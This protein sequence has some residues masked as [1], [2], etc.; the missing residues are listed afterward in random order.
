[1]LELLRG[2]VNPGANGRQVLSGLIPG[3][4]GARGILFGPL[5]RFARSGQDAVGFRGGL[6]RGSG[7]P[8]RLRRLLAEGR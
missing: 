6:A 1:L 4:V 5:D 7:S 2:L 3:A 8:L